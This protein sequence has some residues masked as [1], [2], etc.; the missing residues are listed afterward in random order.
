MDEL[1]ITNLKLYCYHGVLASEKEEG[2]YFFV[3]AKLKLQLQGAGLTDDLEKSVNYAMVCETIGRVMQSEK[4]NLIEKVAEEVA[5]ALFE[6]FPL[7]E[8]LEL[9]IRKPEAPIPM[10]F[11]C[12]S[13]LIRRSRHKVYIGCGSNIGDGERTINEAINRLAESPQCRLL[14]LSSMYRTK[15]Y[16][17]VE[18][19][20]YT[21][22][23]AFIETTLEPYELLHWL[24]TVEMEFGRTR[25]VHWGP[26]TLDLDI[27]LYDHL[28]MDDERLTLPHADMSNRD[29]VLEPLCELNSRYIH[30]VLNKTTKELLDLVKEKYVIK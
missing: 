24:N 11:E 17:G 30:P 19:D 14:G 6:E 2:Q 26:R 27:L 20:D 10:D 21:N 1:R 9:E 22:A 4:W 13:A 29:F 12:V 15:P 8:G 7:I 18:Q 25:E 23:V 5:T 3:N 16:G 28:V